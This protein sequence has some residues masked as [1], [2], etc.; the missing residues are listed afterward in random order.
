MGELVCEK[1]A[2]FRRWPAG[3]SPHPGEAPQWVWRTVHH[4]NAYGGDTVPQDFRLRQQ[5]LSVCKALFE[6]AQSFRGWA[7][8]ADGFVAA[9]RGPPEW[10]NLCSSSA[11]S[12]KRRTICTSRPSSCPVQLCLSLKAR[13]LK[14]PLTLQKVAGW[15]QGASQAGR[16]HLFLVTPR[17]KRQL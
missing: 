9:A 5:A 6:C 16:Q 15:Y 3:R 11:C 17:L 8:A 1:F 10:T 14:S 7:C 2:S 13:T 12:A 4:G